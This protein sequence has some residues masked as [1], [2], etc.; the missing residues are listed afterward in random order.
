[1]LRGCWRA[2]V[3]HPQRASIRTSLHPHHVASPLPPAGAASSP[4]MAGS[5]DEDVGSNAL[6]QWLQDDSEMPPSDRAQAVI[7]LCFGCIPGFDTGTH[8]F[9]HKVFDKCKKRHKPKKDVLKKEIKRRGIKTSVSNKSTNELLAALQD[10]SN[11]L[12]DE[13]L[14]YLKSALEVYCNTPFFACVT[15][16]PYGIEHSL[17]LGIH[18]CVHNL[19]RLGIFPH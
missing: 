14:D 15:Q 13:D 1:L 2:F 6:R 12:P 4:T 17:R 5:D 3:E 11:A 19:F 9:N 7:T 16:C 10:E 18:A 8:P